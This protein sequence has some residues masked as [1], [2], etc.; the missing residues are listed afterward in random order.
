MF[1]AII[2]LSLIFVL[3]G[4]AGNAIVMWLLGF[5]MHRNAFSVYILNLAVADFLFLSFE[6]VYFL[7]LFL[8]IFY[9]IP[10]Y[11]HMPWVY[12]LVPTIAYLSGLSILSA[13]SVERCLSVLCPIW[14]RCR[15]PRH[16]SAVTCALLWAL[17]LLLSLL[18]GAACGFLFNNLDSFQCQT[19]NYFTASWLI[20]LF[21]V[22]CVSSLTLLVRIFCGSQRIPVTRLCVIIVLTVLFSLIFGFPLGIYYHLVKWFGDLDYAKICNLDNNIVSLLSC[23]NSCANPIIYFLIGSIRHRRFQPKSLKLLLQRALQDTPENEGGERACP[24]KTEE[25]EPL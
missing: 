4:L 17:S 25:R 22:L 16:T 11:I 6:F 21:V 10:I 3:L 20:V 14:Y 24:R 7:H 13:I 15:R 19:L 1:Q 12:P 23:V 9:S 18:H 8:Y 2:Y 5:R